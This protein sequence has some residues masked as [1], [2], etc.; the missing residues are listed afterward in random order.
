MSETGI[1]L[2]TLN[3]QK[4]WS[5]GKR[6]M[7]IEQIK[8]NLIASGANIVCLQEVVGA[9]HQ[10]SHKPQFEYLADGIWQHYAYGKN[11][12]SSK[13]HHGNAILSELPFVKSENFDISNHK[14]ERR[15]ILYGVVNSPEAVGPDIHIMTVH[16]DLTPWGRLR[17]LE[18]LCQLIEEKVSHS[19]PLIVCGDFND[20]SEEL[21]APLFEKVAL[22]EAYF[23]VKGEHAKTFP[24][25]LP[26]LRLDRIYFRNLRVKS[27]KRLD[28]QP[29]HQLSDHLGL[30]VEFE[31][32]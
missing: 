7:T 20:W 31:T 22:K 15:G 28:A 25:F 14:L 21:S 12:I 19:E 2:L 24:T 9:H 30:F 5:I 18:K 8:K 6:R 29:W 27:V 11:A 10:L 16:L 13:G 4:G 3:I 32:L 1:K 26:I 23:T 17:Q